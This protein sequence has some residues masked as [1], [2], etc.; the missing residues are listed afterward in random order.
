M[1]YL[2]LEPG[3]CEQNT[4]LS[5]TRQLYEQPINGR[6]TSTEDGRAVQTYLFARTRMSIA[7]A[8]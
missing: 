6:G 5:V 4:I 2:P 1:L 7:V 3:M 8:T